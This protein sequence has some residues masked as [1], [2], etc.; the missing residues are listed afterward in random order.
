MPESII[1]IAV[2]IKCRGLEEWIASEY[3]SHMKRIVDRVT[4]NE[5]QA[6]CWTTQELLEEGVLYLKGCIYWLKGKLVVLPGHKFI[7]KRDGEIER[8]KIGEECYLDSV[9]LMRKST[10]AI[11]RQG[12]EDDP[13]ANPKI[14]SIRR[15]YEIDISGATDEFKWIIGMSAVLKDTKDHGT[16]GRFGEIMNGRY[17]MAIPICKINEN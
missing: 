14:N 7:V 12:E 8:R 9:E 17:T 4:V 11:L 6:S 5:A 3:E 16:G 10:G 1:M 13:N 15:W 2:K